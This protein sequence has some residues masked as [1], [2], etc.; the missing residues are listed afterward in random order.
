MAK[1][2][3]ENTFGTRI[4]NA[5]TLLTSLQTFQNY[6]PSNP[7]DSIAEIQNIIDDLSV[8]YEDEAKNAHLYTAAADTRQKAF[9]TKETGIKAITTFIVASLRAQYGKDSLQVTSLNEL[10]NKTRGTNRSAPK[11]DDGSKQVSTSQRSYAS[12]TQ[13][14]ADIISS[15]SVLSPA[16]APVNPNVTIEKLKKILTEAQ[17][18]NQAVQLAELQLKQAR[19]KRDKLYTELNIRTQRIKESVKAIYGTKSTEYAAIKGLKI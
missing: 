4:N 5:K 19:E 8:S 12:T 15:L 7:D 3:S 11:T 16:Y 2:V 9:S 1:K 13:N 10:I 17:E 6:Q 18:S 14:F